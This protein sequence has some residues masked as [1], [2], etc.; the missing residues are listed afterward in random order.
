MVYIKVSRKRV[1]LTEVTN[2]G[3]DSV[4]TVKQ[5]FNKP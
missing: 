1:G 5:E 3:L 4:A 2:G